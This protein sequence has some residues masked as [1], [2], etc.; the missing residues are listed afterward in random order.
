MHD[1]LDSLVIGHF[2]YGLGL[3]LGQRTG[4]T[5]PV[6][7]V[8]LLQQAQGAGSLGDF[9]HRRAATVRLIEFSGRARLGLQ[10]RRKHLVLQAALRRQP[11]LKAIS[12]RLHW[13][14]EVKPVAAGG[15]AARGPRFEFHFGARPYLDWL[16]GTT[17]DEDVD[18]L[19]DAIVDD[20]LGPRERHDDVLLRDYLVTVA[21]FAGRADGLAGMLIAVDAVAGIQWIA[22]KDLRDLRHPPARLLQRAGL[23]LMDETVVD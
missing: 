22:F 11:D 4:A 13:Q 23:E 20:A 3:R 2:L 21:R 16:A 6:A 19:L 1:S 14:V 12:R 5:A 7:C 18:S 15:P 10:G 17:P 9:L 8:S